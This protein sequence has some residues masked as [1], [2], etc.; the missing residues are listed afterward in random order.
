MKYVAVLP[1]KNEEENI[2]SAIESLVQQ[3]IPPVR[4]LVIDDHSS[5]ATADIVRSLAEQYSTVAYHRVE[6]SPEYT[7]G[8]HVVRIFMEGKKL[9]DAEGIEYDWI[10]KMDADVQS[11][12]DFVERL[13]GR[14]KGRK[15]GIVSGTPYTEE[16]GERTYDTSPF[17]HTHGQFKFYQAN[18]FAEVGGPREHLGWDCADN[19]RA[20]S[21]GWECEAIRNL[22][23]LMHREVGGKTTN[24]QGR[25][26]HGIGC[27]ICG[28]GPGYFLLK[29]LHDIPK[30]PVLSG[31]LSLVRGYLGAALRREK[32]VL[33]KSQ[34]K[35]LRRLLWSS[36]WGRFRNRDFVMLQKVATRKT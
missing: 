17:W 24:K 33:T 7:L 32:K 18:C 4:L 26:N 35:L 29:V 9:L 27:Y 34:R 16:N 21:A 25:L 36:L 14:V 20:I 6:S 2:R 5:D 19:V 31:S 8:G 12:P 11:E 15:V 23:Y 3:S 10:V 30:P 13:A 1:A 28:F 22:N